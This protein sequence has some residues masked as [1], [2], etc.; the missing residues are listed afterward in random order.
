MRDDFDYDLFVIGAGSGGVRTARMV[1]ETGRKVAIAEEF[2]SGGA[3]VIRGCVPKKLYAYA[4][5]FRD[6]YYVAR[7]FGFDAP[8]INFNW[9][10]LRDNKEKEITRLEHIYETRLKEAGVTLFKSRAVLEGSNSIRLLAEDKIITAK[11]IVIAVGG[12]PRP[13]E[14][15]GHSIGMTS[16]E[17]FDM[18]ALPDKIFIYGGGYIGVEFASIF[19]GLGVDVTIGY[20]GDKILGGFDDDI[21]NSLIEEY[22]S[23]GIKLIPFFTT[24]KMTVQDGVL[25]FIHDGKPQEFKYILNASGRIPNTKDLGLEKAGV[26][27]DK[28]GTIIVDK[29]SKTTTD[30]IYAVG[31]VTNRLT[32]TPVAI[33]EAMCLVQTLCHNNPVAPDYE[34]VPTAVFTTPEIGSVGFCEDK[35]I[36]AGYSIDIYES[37]FRTMKYSLSDKSTKNYMK[38]IVD[39][40]TDVVLGVHI[41]GNDSAEIIQCIGIAIKA[42]LTKKQFDATMAVHPSIAEEL[43]TMRKPSRTIENKIKKFAP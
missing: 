1:A 42:R 36:A 27:T 11:N 35:A 31:D 24:D 2:R 21:R 7:S 40:E 16:D 28:N 22:L 30:S 41:F 32:L 4:S 34:N 5:R 20:R 29:Y 10:I 15:H 9:N 38:M 26:K 12:V 13:L 39:K 33:E 37:R 14:T 19:H 3:C 43:V 8:I 23:S 6:D 25:S 17:I 18:P